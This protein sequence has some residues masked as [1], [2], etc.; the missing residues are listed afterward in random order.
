[1][2]FR[3]SFIEIGFQA[4]LD[5][6]VLTI[7]QHFTAPVLES[8]QLTLLKYNGAAIPEPQS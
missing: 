5:L 1:M 2:I 7:F 3:T 6:R 4:F 8:V